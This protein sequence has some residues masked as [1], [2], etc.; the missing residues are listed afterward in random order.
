MHKK[1][2]E[3]NTDKYRIISYKVYENKLKEL[4]KILYEKGFDPIVIKGWAAAQYYPQPWNRNLGDV[5]LVFD[6]KKADEVK[7]VLPEIT[8]L[9]IDVHCGLR[10]L[11]TV[12][13]EDLYEQSVLK[14]CMGVPVRCL[15]V[16][17]HLRVLCVHWMND[18]GAYKEKLWDIFYAV[19][20]SRESFDW[21]R[22]LDVVSATRRNWILSMIA[23]THDYIGLKIDDLPF[24]GELKTVPQWL[25]N[26][27]EKEWKSNVRLNSLHL[28]IKDREQ[29][30]KQIRK[31]I[32]PNSLQAIVELEKDIS[33]AFR[34]HYQILNVFYRMKP[35]ARRIFKNEK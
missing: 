4:I 12:D 18:G 26:S 9:P 33:S 29:L 10:H 32:P 17:D 6:T 27:V 21:R 25:K 35:S 31:R 30:V 23:L 19:E 15:R 13:F 16:E 28:Y 8:D 24:A 20:S 14:D 7:D 34:F 3:Q 11:D 1:I 22:C 2:L 5:D